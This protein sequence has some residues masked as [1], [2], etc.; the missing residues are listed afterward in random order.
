MGHERYPKV[1][2]LDYM[3][4]ALFNLDTGYWG[5]LAIKFNWASFVKATFFTT[6]WEL[7]YF[8][9]WEAFTELACYPFCITENLKNEYLV[10]TRH[11]LFKR[12]IAQFRLRNKHC[13]NVI[14]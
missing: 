12:I 8:N 6:I 4:L 3:L 1:M 10:T 13:N 5:N 2:D 9:N 11:L 7:D 14:S